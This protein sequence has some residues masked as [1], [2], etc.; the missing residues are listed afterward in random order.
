[1]R[2]APIEGKLGGCLNCGPRPSDCPPD[3]MLAVGFGFV[4]VT[5]NGKL[6]WGGDDERRTLREFHDRA[7]VDYRADW[8]VSFDAPLSSTVYQL[9]K[10]R[11][12]LVEQ[13][14]GFA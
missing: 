8:R 11:W 12:V 6:I 1:M 10:G 4:A 2:L 3:T 14:L 13:G 5:R 9:Q 7:V